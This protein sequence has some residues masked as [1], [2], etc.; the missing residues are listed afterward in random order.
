[1]IG[2]FLSQTSV[3]H[4]V[5]WE[6][7]ISSSVLK[8]FIYYSLSTHTQTFILMLSDVN[9]EPWHVLSQPASKFNLEVGLWRSL[10]DLSLYMFVYSDASGQVSNDVI[11]NLASGIVKQTKEG[12]MLS[13][14][15]CWCMAAGLLP[16]VAWATVWHLWSV[17]RVCFQDSKENVH[18]L[19]IWSSGSEQIFYGDTL[20]PKHKWHLT[21]HS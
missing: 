8:W 20:I 16:L 5:W 11:R 3:A 19:N 12:V 18:R 21:S 9:I 15:G 10:L 7:T 2:S 17:R 6:Y 4:F 1:M 14:A 13:D